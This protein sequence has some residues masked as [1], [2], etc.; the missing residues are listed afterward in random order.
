V[1]SRLYGRKDM[2]GIRSISDSAQRWIMML[3]LPLA[4]MIIVY[5]DDMLRFLFGSAYAGGASALSVFI[6][7]VL[8]SSLTSVFMVPLNVMMRL[9]LQIG[10]ALLGGT[11]LLV[12]N[13]LLIWQ[14]GMLGAVLSSLISSLAVLL[15]ARHYS[16]AISGV[17]FSPHLGRLI[18]AALIAFAFLFLLKP[19]V[20]PAA[21]SLLGGTDSFSVVSFALRLASVAY[22][23][24]LAAIS[25]FSFITCAI[26]LRCFRKEDAEVIR[27][28]GQKLRMPAWILQ[29]AERM[30]MIE[31]GH[32]GK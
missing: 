12:A 19:F 3:F 20:S 21:H 4:A 29:S 32:G 27:M 28:I 22:F 23:G 10:I 9:R 17:D 25:F 13:V 24:A 7:A 18:L 1:M 16:A 6:L 8:F 2:A 5:S 31:P 30:L 14:Y 15:A 11:I 26:I